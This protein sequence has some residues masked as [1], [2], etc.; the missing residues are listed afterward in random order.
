MGDHLPHCS[1]NL[2]RRFRP[3]HP[4]SPPGV[5]PE[6]PPECVCALDLDDPRQS[7]VTEPTG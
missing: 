6:P 5:R 4:D 3:I 1:L 7:E 2:N